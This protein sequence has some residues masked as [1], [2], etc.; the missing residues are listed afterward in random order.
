MQ[1]CSISVAII[2][3]KIQTAM[4]F[5]SAPKIGSTD[6][7]QKEAQ[8]MFAGG[9]TTSLKCVVYKFSDVVLL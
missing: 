4:S 8:L 3:A 6:L 7:H 2:L 9:G 5:K 1:K